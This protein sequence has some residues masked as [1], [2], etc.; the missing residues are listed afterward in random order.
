MFLRWGYGSGMT[1]NGTATA[2]LTAEQITDGLQVTF[3]PDFSDDL[4][5][6]VW[7]I[8][9]LPSSGALTCEAAADAHNGTAAYTF[10]QIRRRVRNGTR[11]G[12]RF[13]NVA[14]LIT[15]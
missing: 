11:W 15:A 14:D 12:Y 6:I 2:A 10:C 1:T 5:G 7:E 3:R 4:R 8:C 13:A 9:P